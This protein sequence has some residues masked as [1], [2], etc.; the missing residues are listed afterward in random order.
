MPWPY[1]PRKS[2]WK[3]WWLDEIKLCTWFIERYHIPPTRVAGL[4][5][6]CLWVLVAPDELLHEPWCEHAPHKH[7]YPGFFTPDYF[8]SRVKLCL[9]HSC[10]SQ[11]QTP[12]ATQHELFSLVFCIETYLREPNVQMSFPTTHRVVLS[13]VLVIPSPLSNRMHVS[14]RTMATGKFMAT[15]ITFKLIHQNHV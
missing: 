11:Y 4:F 7:I 3:K 14:N 8:Y 10:R 13:R 12:H 6:S 5:S 2:T 9:C 1:K 15:S